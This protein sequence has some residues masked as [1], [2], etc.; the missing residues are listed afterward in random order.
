MAGQG[1]GKKRMNIVPQEDYQRLGG[2]STTLGSFP[3]G[4][5]SDLS[6]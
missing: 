6:S 4:R 5:A 3:P 2:N 1:P